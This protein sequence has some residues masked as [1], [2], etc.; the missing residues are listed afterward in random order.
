MNV[1]NGSMPFKFAIILGSG[2]MELYYLFQLDL[3]IVGGYYGVGVSDISLY[4]EHVL[5][6]RRNCF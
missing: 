1:Q 3:L 5:T 2:F 6:F 4:L